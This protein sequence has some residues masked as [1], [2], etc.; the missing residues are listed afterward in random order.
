[1]LRTRLGLHTSPVAVETGKFDSSAGA[2][3][4]AVLYLPTVPQQRDRPAKHLLRPTRNR[5]RYRETLNDGVQ[6]TCAHLWRRQTCVDRANHLQHALALRQLGIAAQ[7]HRPCWRHHDASRCPAT[8]RRPA[9]RPAF[10]ESLPDVS[11]PFRRSTRRV[12][13]RAGPAT[14]H[15]DVWVLRPLSS[16]ALCVTS[17]TGCAK[18]RGQLSLAVCEIVQCGIVTAEINPDGPHPSVVPQRGC[19]NSPAA[20]SGKTAK[21]DRKRGVLLRNDCI[22]GPNASFLTLYSIAIRSKIH[23]Y[24]KATKN[25]RKAS[26]QHRKWERITMRLWVCQSRLQMMS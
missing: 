3:L 23:S 11:I 22:R 24:W 16:A 26:G 13:C 12:C 14:R 18:A 19:D 4:S 2:A 8:S 1:M 20:P 25:W 21:T 15:T 5:I 10:A 9:G 17:N 6:A 7:P